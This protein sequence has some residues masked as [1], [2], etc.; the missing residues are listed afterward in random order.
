MTVRNRENNIMKTTLGSKRKAQEDGQHCLALPLQ[1]GQ[2]SDK[3]NW[4]KQG[5]ELEMELN[6]FIHNTRGMTVD[7][8]EIKRKTQRHKI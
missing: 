7:R 6:F 1:M 4:Q 5:N 2:D 8:E 3:H